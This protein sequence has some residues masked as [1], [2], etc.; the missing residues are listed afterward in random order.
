MYLSFERLRP[1]SFQARMTIFGILLFFFSALLVVGFSGFFL[2]REFETRL[3]QNILGQL[4]RYSKL[5]LQSRALL[6]LTLQQEHDQNRMRGTWLRWQEDQGT[7]WETI[8]ANWEQDPTR[9]KSLLQ[10][11]LVSGDEWSRMPSKNVDLSNNSPPEEYHNLDLE[12]EI[13]ITARVFSDGS[14]LAIG[15]SHAFTKLQ[16]RLFR[17]RVFRILL[18]VGIVSIL[19]G[20]FFTRKAL[21]PIQDLVETT[22]TIAAGRLDARVPEPDTSG[23]LAKL[24]RLYNEMLERIEHLVTTMN[25]SLDNV[26]HDLR[27]PLM[28][29]RNSIELTIANEAAS[30]EELREALLDVAEEAEQIQLLLTALMNQAEAVAGT[31]RLSKE[32]IDINVLTQE[33]CE[34]YELLAEEKQITLRKN[35]AEASVFL[36]ADPVRLRQ[37]LGNLLD[38]AIKFTPERG[39][40]TVSILSQPNVV[41]IEIKDTGVGISESDQLRIFERLYRGDKSRSTKGMGLGLSLVQGVI[42]SHGADIRVIS[43]PNQGSTFRIEF[44]RPTS[45]EDRGQ[46]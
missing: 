27:T 14:V 30:V 10:T 12:E 44:L 15:E 45:I 20:W 7:L 11:H 16:I 6:L 8:P 2:H 5:H 37:A 1:R 33:A 40:I 25:E 13:L 29:L 19:V 43:S 34:P 23:E 42:Q 35:F 18:A 39:Q 9:L 21:R 36:E 22:E 41:I 28:R 32:L 17:R 4:E 26:A 38:N 24:T 46:W 3:Q 31:M